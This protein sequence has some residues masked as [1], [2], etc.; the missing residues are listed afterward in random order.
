MQFV[1]D[2]LN[3]DKIKFTNNFYRNVL[4]EYK[5]LVSDSKEININ[6]FLHHEN[7]TIQQLSISFVSKKHEISSRWEDLHQIFIEDETKNLEITIE[8]AVLSLKQAYIKSEI[9]KINNR[10]KE[11]KDPS[12]QLIIKLIMLPLY[13]Q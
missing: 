8:K 11:E 9:V 2:E 7:D 13:H 1:F 3:H 12:I 4:E 10:M 6:H 5:S